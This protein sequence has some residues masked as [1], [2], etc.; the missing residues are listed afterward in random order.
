MKI[1][2]LAAGLGTRVAGF[3]SLPK[4]FI[5]VRGKTILEWSLSS[6]HRCQAAGLIGPA[7]YLVVV[8]KDH[9]DQH[10]VGELIG[11]FPAKKVGL[12]E[13]N[14]VTA[15]PAETAAKAVLSAVDSGQI[16]IDE[17][18]IINDCDHFFDSG[19]VYRS[20]KDLALGYSKTHLLFEATKTP[21]DLSWSFLE[22][23][24]EDLVGVRE[25]PLKSELANIDSSRGLAGVY[26]WSSAGE[27]LELYGKVFGPVGEA[28]PEPFISAVADFA[29]KSGWKTIVGTIRDFV[30]L[31]SEDQ[32]RVAERSSLLCAGFKEPGAVLVDI[33]GTLV[34]HDAGFFSDSGHYASRLIPLDSTVVDS[35]VEMAKFGLSIVLVSSRPPSQE[36]F[37]RANFARL[38]IPCDRLILGLSGGAR[39]LVNDIKPSLPGIPTAMSLNVLRNRPDFLL[40]RETI[41]RNENTR[42]VADFPGESGAIT[43]LLEIDGTRRV[44]RKSSQGSPDSRELMQYQASWFNHIGNLFPKV[45]PSV[46]E[47]HFSQGDARWSFDTEYIPAIVPAFEFLR[48]QS[49][50]RASRFTQNLAET[51]NSIYGAHRTEEK[52]NAGVL[53]DV[54][55]KKSLPGYRKAMETLGILRE[56]ALSNIST[57]W[58]KYRIFLQVWRI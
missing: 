48:S 4:P 58:D 27:F 33:D 10:S 3:S 42:V 57:P 6:F 53:F 12:I 56:L 22:R 55:A 47:T 9:Q 32:I 18:L 13:I 31:G 15:G 7:D 11:L 45:V 35:L 25:K 54:L 20:I 21:D 29:I 52:R 37:L 24:D 39:Y 2:T 34:E 5:E 44:I 19:S 30:P 41:L 16:G 51:L 23:Q 1:L 17:P 40:V 26:G 43:Q 49:R 38:G 50:S 8:Q 36:E 46:S 14:H 28:T